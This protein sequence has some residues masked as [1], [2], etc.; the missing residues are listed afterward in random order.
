MKNRLK[1]LE[2]IIEQVEKISPGLTDQQKERLVNK[3]IY[4]SEN[5]TE[6]QLRRRC[7]ASP[8]EAILRRIFF[9]KEVEE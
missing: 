6:E 8:Q 2:Q 1:K 3:L 9:S 4:L 5:E 7:E